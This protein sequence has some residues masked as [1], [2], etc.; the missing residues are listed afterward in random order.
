CPLLLTIGLASRLA[1][2]CLLALTAA[3]GAVQFT[4]DQPAYLALL[5]GWVVAIGPGPLSLDHPL[6]AGLDKSAVPLAGALRRLFTAIGRYGGPAYRL[7]L[8]ILLAVLFF[9]SGLAMAG[10]FA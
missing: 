7:A 3:T 10:D 1:A 5:L 9:R 4:A 8:R 2:A 6:A